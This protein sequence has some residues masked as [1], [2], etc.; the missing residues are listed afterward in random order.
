M[1]KTVCRCGSRL[2]L[3]GVMLCVVAAAG[4]PVVDSTDEPTEAAPEAAWPELVSS[5]GVKTVPLPAPAHGEEKPFESMLNESGDVWQVTER[6]PAEVTGASSGEVFQTAREVDPFVKEG[7]LVGAREP[8]ERTPIVVARE[9]RRSFLKQIPKGSL[10][11]F[12]LA[13]FI[14]AFII[15]RARS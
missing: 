5:N 6:G 11:N 10:L 2:G 15:L 3:L 4:S 7:D 12:L 9:D 14:L 13:V 1:R 8:S